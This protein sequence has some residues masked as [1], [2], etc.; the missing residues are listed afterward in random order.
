MT[1][2]GLP[3]LGRNRSRQERERR[4]LADDDVCLSYPGAC[5]VVEVQLFGVFSVE[6]HGDEVLS[7][8]V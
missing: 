8:V 6:L 5:R 2:L 1:L 4:R 7:C 3:P